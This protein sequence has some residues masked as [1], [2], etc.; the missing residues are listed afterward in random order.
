MKYL[1]PCLACGKFCSCGWQ[2]LPLILKTGVVMVL[3]SK[4]GS[5][6]DELVLHRGG[7]FFWP[8]GGARCQASNSHLPWGGVFYLMVWVDPVA[9]SFHKSPWQP[10]PRLMTLPL[11]TEHLPSGSWCKDAGT[12]GWAVLPGGSSGDLLQPACALV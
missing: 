3:I 9:L 7:F 12:D 1:E 5:E 8:I 10:K 11:P 2:T 6:N 4:G